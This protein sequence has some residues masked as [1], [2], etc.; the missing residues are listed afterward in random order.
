MSCFAIIFLFEYQL[1]RRETKNNNFDKIHKKCTKQILERKGK[2]YL[3]MRI[4]SCINSKQ[5]VVISSDIF[6]TST[7]E[8]KPAKM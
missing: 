8:G 3:K 1:K 7:L 5:C 4:F 6:G 2:L